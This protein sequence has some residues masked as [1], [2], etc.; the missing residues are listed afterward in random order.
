M[1]NLYAGSNPEADV[2][3][4]PQGSHGADKAKGLKPVKMLTAY[5]L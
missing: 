5:Y 2:A 4:L 3:K 1:Y